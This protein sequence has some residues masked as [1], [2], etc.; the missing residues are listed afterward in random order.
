MSLKVQTD[1][2]VFVTWVCYLLNLLVHRWGY[3]SCLCETLLESVRKYR[4]YLKES[5]VFMILADGSQ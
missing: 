4:K 2:V 1:S 5:D 3:W